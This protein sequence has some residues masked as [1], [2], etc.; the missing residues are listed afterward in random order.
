V[1]VEAVLHRVLMNTL[2]VG[3]G[4]NNH[5][6]LVTRHSQFVRAI[7]VI[8]I[9]GAVESRSNKIL[10]RWTQVLTQV[11]KIEAKGELL[12]IIGDFNAHVGDVINENNLNVSQGGKY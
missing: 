1:K 2:K 8:N 3:E 11:K 5:E 7:N 12:V 10:S 9:Y 6:M 4:E